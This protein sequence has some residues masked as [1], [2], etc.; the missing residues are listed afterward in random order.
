M[1]SECLQSEKDRGQVHLCHGEQMF[2]RQTPAGLRL[3]ISNDVTVSQGQ[4][5]QALT[6]DMIMNITNFTSGSKKIQQI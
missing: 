1:A 2:V 5:C 6:V 3:C 4:L